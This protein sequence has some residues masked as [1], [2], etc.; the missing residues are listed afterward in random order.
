MKK[1][2]LIICLVLLIFIFR[3][4]CL[5]AQAQSEGTPSGDRSSGQL[6]NPPPFKVGEKF[7]YTLTWGIIPAGFATMEVDSILRW[8]GGVDCYLL[9]ITAGTNSFLD[10]IHKVRD[11]LSSL[12]ETSL[13]RS[14]YYR[15]EQYEGSFHRDDELIIDYAGGEVILNRNGKLKKTIKI[16]SDDDLL[17]PYAVLYYIR[18]L[19]LRVGD[20]IK[21][22]VTDGSAVYQMQIN[23]LKRERVKS[24]IGYFDC[25]KI[26]PRM[27]KI[28]GIF[29]KKPNSKL[30]VWL[31]DDSRK[32]P[33]KM[34][35]E[36]SIGSVQGV[37]KE[38]HDP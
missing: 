6:S 34:Q 23:V 20:K 33:V 18:S 5:S 22:R 35:S 27:E 13:K 16:Q 21:T 10:K 9:K 38:I 32:I 8:G 26:E 4:S 30:Y 11:T 24:W 3:S 25:L 7:T 19:N 37:L 31:S 14:Q 12:I 28:E 17:D 36:V 2:K 1:I 29:N 15:K